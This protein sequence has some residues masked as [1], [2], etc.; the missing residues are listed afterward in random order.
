[1]APTYL[2]NSLKVYDSL[3]LQQIKPPLQSLTDI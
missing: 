2:S 3:D 1:M